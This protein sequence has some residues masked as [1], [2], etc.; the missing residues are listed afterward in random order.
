MTPQ[1]SG[2]D[3]SQIDL[4]PR[5]HPPPR[6]EGGGR[7]LFGRLSRSAVV[8]LSSRL[9]LDSTTPYSPLFIGE[10]TTLERSPIIIQRPLPLRRPPR[11]TSNFPGVGSDVLRNR[12]SM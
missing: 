5:P 4:H 6:T 7:G 2:G 9:Y 12:S 3:R 11:P 1:A 10:G 8:V